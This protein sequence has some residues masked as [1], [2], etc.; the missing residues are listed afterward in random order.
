MRRALLAAALSIGVLAVAAVPARADQDDFVAVERGRAL[1][2]AG[3]C[4]ACHTAPGRPPFAGGRALETPFG[5]INSANLTPEQETGIGT[6]SADDFYRAMHEGKRPGGTHLYPAFPY[7]YYT[8]VTR[9]DSDAIFAFLRNLP[10]TSNR[11]DR[12][13]LPFPFD[14]RTSMVAWNA[15]NFTEGEYQPDP[16]RSDEFNRG[17][18]LVEG[19]G[20]CGACHTPM[21][22]MGGSKDSIHLQGNQ[23]QAWVAPNITND[24]RTG[25][26]SWSADEIV[27]YLRTGRTAKSAASGP[28]A[29]VVTYSTSQMPEVDL[30]A[31]AI[32]LKERGAGAP[33][34]PAALAAGSPRMAAGQ[35]IFTD[36]CK[37]CHVE[38]GAGIPRL[39]PALAGSQVVQQTDPTTLIRIVVT[40]TRAAATRDAPTA[41]AM[42]AL[43]WRLSDDQIASVLT[44]IRN[45]WGNAAPEVSPAAV[46]GIRSRVATRVE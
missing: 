38:T 41:P 18:Y 28:M 46:A 5:N 29:E 42:P 19:L 33:S 4:I 9:A 34:A 31:I 7:P 27:E 26:G 24:L 13:T 43:G 35:S 21:N 11:V 37:A 39:F 17:G 23:I 10:A 14:I 40:G 45:A 20:H 2:T 32:Y 15:V 1:V 44:Y 30:R 25:L 12:D 22:V 16:G 36:T 3:D 8:K 6:W